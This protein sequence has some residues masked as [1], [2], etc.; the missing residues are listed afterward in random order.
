M[1]T[2]ANAIHKAKKL[3]QNTGMLLH[4]TEWVASCHRAECRQPGWY[5]GNRMALVPYVDESFF[6]LHCFL[7]GM[8]V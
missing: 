1:T 3:A 4:P 7:R 5:R 8:H 2:L 6:C